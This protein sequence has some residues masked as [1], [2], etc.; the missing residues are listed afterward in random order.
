MLG[1]A[2]LVS[3]GSFVGEKL[4]KLIISD[5]AKAFKPEETKRFLIDREI[6]WKFSLPHALW[7]GGAFERMV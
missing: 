6:L 7:T 3:V 4:Q 2:F 5:N 1:L